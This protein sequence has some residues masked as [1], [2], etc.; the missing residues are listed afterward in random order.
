MIPRDHCHAV[1]PCLNEAP[2]IGRLVREAARH[3]GA[4]WVIDDASTDGT[5]TA[6]RDAGAHVI[7]HPATRGKGACLRAGWRAVQE[8]GIPW[9]LCLDGDGQ[10]RPSDIPHFLENASRTGADLVVGDRMHAAD[11]MPWLRRATNRTLSAWL[12]RAGG[13]AF[14]DSQCG[15][16]LVRTDR[17]HEL[18]L[19]TEHF[20]IESELLLAAARASWR[21]EFV[22]IETVY[23]NEHSKIRPFRD[24]WRWLRWFRH[25]RRNPPAAASPA[26]GRSAV[27][28]LRQPD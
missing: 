4:V 19:T 20:E 6:A 21:I 10:H 27:S 17:L 9:A 16:R 13:R 18:V 24:A 26:P 11:R 25:A 5:A 2:A 15:F 12:S 28:A 1:I 22:P 14:P 7:Q 3:L 23:A 8:Q